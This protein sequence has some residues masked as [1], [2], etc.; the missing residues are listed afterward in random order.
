MESVVVTGATGALG[1]SLLDQL[2]ARTRGIVVGT[3]RPSATEAQR[4][5]LLARSPERVRLVEID[6][7]NPQSAHAAV[8]AVAPYVSCVEMLI[9]C[10]AVNVAASFPRSAAKG[11]FEALDAEA[12]VEMFR[13]NATGALSAIQAFTPLLERAQRPW[14]VNVS[15]ER[16]SLTRAVATGSVGYAVSKAALNMLTRK[17]AAERGPGG[18][19]VVAV[20]PGWFRSPIGG[21]NAPLEPAAAAA[22]L[23]ESLDTLPVEVTGSGGFVDL[24]GTSIPW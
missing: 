20:H 8:E 12:L 13:V 6:H 9:N 23:L 14:V 16:A 4:S 10:A 18:W 17:L 11:P 22:R 19:R 3:V 1:S 5:Q 7:E 24:D 2:L 21:A 15:T